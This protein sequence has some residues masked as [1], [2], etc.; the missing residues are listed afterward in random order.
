MYQAV[1]YHKTVV[2]FDLMLQKV[3]EELMTKNKAHGY[4]D[5]CK[6][7]ESELCDFNDNYVWNLLVKH[8]KDPSFI[9][10]LINMLRERKRLKKIKDINGVS[11]FGKELP[12]YTTMKLIELDI[13]KKT[14]SK[15]SGVPEEWIFCSFPK[16]LQILSN[17]EDEPAI[18]VALKDGHHKPIANDPAS[19]IHSLY[20]SCYLYARI[21]TEENKETSLLKGIH[22][23]FNI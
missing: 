19:I 14:L 10:T 22:N 5:I 9:G 8:K 4:D 18:W 20:K 2:G 1:Y 23:C 17:P 13:Q 16:P 21:Y 15:K 3:Y 6:M 12:D 11:L 7:S